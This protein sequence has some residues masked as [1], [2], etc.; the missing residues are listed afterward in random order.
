MTNVKKRDGRSE[1]FDRSKIERSIRASGL[2]EKAAKEVAKM[3]PEREGITSDEIRKTVSREL[4]KRDTKVADRYDV[5][6]R[7]AAKKAVE[8]AK[9]SAHLTEDAMKGMNLQP[10][11]TVELLHG[12]NRRTVKVAKTTTGKRSIHL[13]ESDLKTLGASE[14][15][16][17]TV[18]R[19]K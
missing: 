9:G 8:A 15:K 14:G 18:H 19:R 12:E 5:T 7:L 10:G 3:V 16:R 1:K 2:D 6:R 4:R 11:D 17:I 13:H